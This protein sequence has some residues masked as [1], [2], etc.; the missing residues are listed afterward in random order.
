MREVMKLVA[1]LALL[2]PAMPHA[3]SRAAGIDRCQAVAGVRPHAVPAAMRT[4]LQQNEVRLTYVGHAS[5]LIET[6]QGVTA[7]TDYN[8]Y[9]RPPLIPDIATMNHAHTSHFTDHPEPAIKHVLRGWAPGGGAVRHDVELRDLSCL[10]YTSPSPRDR[11]R[12]RM[13]SSA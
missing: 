2:I 8:D 5:F 1:L 6:P 13:P 7:V 9:V 11:T 4:A 10:L 12:S 3:P